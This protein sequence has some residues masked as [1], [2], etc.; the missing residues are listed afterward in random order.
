M[1][2]RPP[3]FWQLLRP[4]LLVNGLLLAWA[5]LSE[6]YGL[7]RTANSV[8]G[9]A[10]GVCEQFIATLV[11]ISLAVYIVVALSPGIWVVQ[12]FLSL[13]V[14]PAR[15]DDFGQALCADI[16]RSRVKY[17]DIYNGGYAY[18]GPIFMSRDFAEYYAGPD[19]W[20]P[21]CMFETGTYFLN[22]GLFETEFYVKFYNG[23]PDDAGLRV[24]FNYDLQKNLFG[25]FV[26]SGR[27]ADPF[28]LVLVSWLSDEPNSEY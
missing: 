15:L 16:L 2:F 10:T 25:I 8:S 13:T 24:S 20:G 4:V 26:F 17:G 22:G 27:R 18:P 28:D 11:L 6:L 23:K 21:V 7:D 19:S 9:F 5:V 12:F 1:K 3:T 14:I